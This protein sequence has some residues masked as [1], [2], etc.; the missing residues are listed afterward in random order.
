MGSLK[1]MMLADAMAAAVAAVDH[2]SRGRYYEP[3][4]AGEYILS[5]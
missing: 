2:A 5:S 3:T 1:T 4:T